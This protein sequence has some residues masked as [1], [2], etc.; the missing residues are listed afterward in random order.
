MSL[1]SLGC[2]QIS[3]RENLS[4]LNLALCRDH[5]TPA[6]QPPSGHFH[7]SAAWQLSD[8]GAL[9]KHG[10]SKGDECP[11]STGVTRLYSLLLGTDIVSPGQ[12]WHHTIISY[13]HAWHLIPRGFVL[14]RCCLF[15][16]SV[17]PISC[18]IAWGYRQGP[19]RRLWASPRMRSISS[20]YTMHG[21]RRWGV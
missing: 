19:V 20:A 12:L 17:C 8:E 14:F 11:L 18:N 13:N 10:Q 16:D 2:V 3:P 1:R 4:S 15:N 5:S 21:S 6:G 9:I 7:A